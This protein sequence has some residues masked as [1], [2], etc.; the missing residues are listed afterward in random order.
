[1]IILFHDRNVFLY[2]HGEKILN[3]KIK[4]TI[5]FIIIFLI[6]LVLVF[7]I[8]FRFFSPEAVM[9]ILGHFSFLGFNESFD[10]LF[11]FL[12][13]VSVIVSILVYICLARLLRRRK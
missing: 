12:V 8:T 9:N 4:K 13:T 5:A 7:D 10:S 3:K 11:V 1:M 6:V 2:Y